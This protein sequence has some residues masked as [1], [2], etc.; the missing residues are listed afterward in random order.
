MTGVITISCVSFLDDILTL[1]N[2]IRLSVH[3]LSVGFMVYEWGLFTAPWYTFAIAFVLIIGIINA[4]N[5]MDGINGI[6]GIYSLV[7]IGSFLY[8]K[9]VNQV[10]FVESELLVYVMLSLLAFI[11]YNFRTKAKCFAGDVGSISIAFI[12]IFLLGLLISRTQDY[13][14]LLMLMIYGLDTITTIIFRLFRKENIFEAH[15]TH[16]YQ[17]L[18]NVQ[19]VHHLVVA[20][21]YAALQLLINA[22]LLNGLSISLLNY[23]LFI[24]TVGGVFIGIRFCFE[25]KNRLLKRKSADNKR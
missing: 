22:V 16:F 19:G 20:S 5:F 23:L 10:S 15:R 4:Y 21:G 17:Y 25:G 12:I 7:T 13:G 1:N 9:E 6:T 24:L 18:V 3:L 11:F 2:K 8:I 14:Y